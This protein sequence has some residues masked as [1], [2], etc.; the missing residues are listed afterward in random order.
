M[1]TKENHKERHIFL[2][3]CLDELVADMIKHTTMLPSNTNI[4]SLMKWSNQQTKS[5]TEDKEVK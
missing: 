3:R 5:P 4:I 2:H 1:N